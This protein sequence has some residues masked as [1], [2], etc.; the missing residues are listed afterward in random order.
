MYTCVSGLVEKFA[1]GFQYHPA[2]LLGVRSG[3]P[4]TAGSYPLE[5]S[6]SWIKTPVPYMRVH[7]ILHWSYGNNSI[8][9]HSGFQVMCGTSSRNSQYHIATYT[10][11]DI[12]LLAG[13]KRPGFALYFLRMLTTGPNPLLL[14]KTGNVRPA[15]EL[16]DWESERL[17][18]S[19]TPD[20]PPLGSIARQHN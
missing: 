10:T 12:H 6:S 15:Y 9:S 20:R 2:F 11:R 17:G 14:C 16:Q 19:Q 13:K 18:R 7:P 4:P 1:D 5:L 3:D 8:T